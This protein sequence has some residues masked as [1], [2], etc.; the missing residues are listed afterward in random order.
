MEPE[1]FEKMISKAVQEAHKK[2]MNEQFQAFGR[3]SLMTFG[4]AV[5][6]A[7]VYFILTVNGWKKP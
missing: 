1:D 2:W 6:F 7:L 3:W 4:A 5:L